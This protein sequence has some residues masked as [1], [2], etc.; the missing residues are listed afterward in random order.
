M[1]GHPDK[2]MSNYSIFMFFF[3]P[4]LVSFCKKYLSLDMI[5]D[6]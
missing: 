1:Q 3:K 2:Y 4:A 6:V 5:N